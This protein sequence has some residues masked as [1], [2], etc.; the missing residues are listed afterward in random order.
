LDE[1]EGYAFRDLLTLDPYSEEVVDTPDAE[2]VLV[3]S[4]LRAL[5]WW[6]ENRDDD[7]RSTGAE[8]LVIRRVLQGSLAVLT[9]LRHA[10]AVDHAVDVL[11]REPHLTPQLARYLEA[12]APRE[13]GFVATLF[14]MPAHGGGEYRNWWQI[15]WLLESVRALQS[16]DKALESRLR[17]HAA[18]SRAPGIVRA[19]STSILLTHER[20]TPDDAVEI[21]QDLAPEARASIVAALAEWDGLTSAQTKVVRS[22]ALS[23]LVFDFYQVPF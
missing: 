11:D 8:S 22:P 17:D 19:S 3:Q 2:D 4:A 13:A 23:R 10:G 15:L 5:E 16:L 1:F 7:H 9:T 18:N 20:M 21:L 12:V 6:R 14:S